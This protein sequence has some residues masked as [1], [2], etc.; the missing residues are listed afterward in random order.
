MLV[1]VATGSRPWCCKQLSHRERFMASKA[2]HQSGLLELH[3]TERRFRTAPTSTCSRPAD[4]PRPRCRTAGSPASRSSQSPG[5]EALAP[6]GSQSWLQRRA[7]VAGLATGPGRAPGHSRPGSWRQSWPQGVRRGGPPREVPRCPAHQGAKGRSTPGADC[8]G[9][10]PAGRADGEAADPGSTVP[11]LARATSSSAVPA[12]PP[13][14][15]RFRAT[16]P[17]PVPRSLQPVGSSAP[18]AA[19]GRTSATTFGAGQAGAEVS[20]RSRREWSKAERSGLAPRRGIQGGFAGEQ[21]PPGL[22]QIAC[23]ALLSTQ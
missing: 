2:E 23:L 4:R 20:D 6:Q 8:R 1:C 3:R 13:A 5:A 15:V 16:Q 18:P 9:H 7:G 11:E 17:R 22:V 10:P 21:G 19:A 14:A 12:T